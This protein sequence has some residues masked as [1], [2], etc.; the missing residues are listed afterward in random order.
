MQ[1]E[2]ETEKGVVTEE[3]VSWSLE[4]LYHNGFCGQT[5]V[6]WVQD[7]SKTYTEE[8]KLKVSSFHTFVLLSLLSNRDYD[9]QLISLL[10]LRTWIEEVLLSLHD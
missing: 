1:K 2:R 10:Y 3:M 8:G 7:W 6:V 9:G 4:Y 5:S